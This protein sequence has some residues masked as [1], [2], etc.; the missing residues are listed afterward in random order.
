[1]DVV[2]GDAPLMKNPEDGREMRGPANQDFPPDQVVEV[3]NA[4][5]G[6]GHQHGRQPLLDGGKRDDRHA[7][8]AAQ[9]QIG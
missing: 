1:M 2:P 6:T 4:V 7:P 3:L 8:G 5:I 9:Q